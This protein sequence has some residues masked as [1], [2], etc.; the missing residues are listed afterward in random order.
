MESNIELPERYKYRFETKNREEGLEYDEY[1]RVDGLEVRIKVKFQDKLINLRNQI[2][3][4][5]K[6]LIE[7]G[8]RKDNAEEAHQNLLNFQP[9]SMN[10]HWAKRINQPKSRPGCLFQ[11]S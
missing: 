5:D 10:Y 2:S 3:Q 11:L 6:E 7:S 9:F 8:K 4:I 1:H